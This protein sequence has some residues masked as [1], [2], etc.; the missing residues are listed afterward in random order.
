MISPNN[1]IVPRKTYIIFVPKVLTFQKI[2]AII[3]VPYI[4]PYKRNI[5]TGTKGV[6]YYANGI[7]LL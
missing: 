4:V 6:N 2:Y 7:W 3:I 5:K 1:I